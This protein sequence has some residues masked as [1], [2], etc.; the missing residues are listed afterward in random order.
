MSMKRAVGTGEGGGAKGVIPPPDFGKLITLF[1]PGG[2]IISTSPSLSDFK[3]YLRPYGM[4]KGAL[5]Q[6]VAMRKNACAYVLLHT[7]P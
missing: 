7:E 6:C 1:Q 5:L 3:T 4:Y 2:Q